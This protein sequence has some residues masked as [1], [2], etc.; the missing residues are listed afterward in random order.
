MQIQKV[1]FSRFFITR[2]F[3]FQLSFVLRP[4]FVSFPVY[5]DKLNTQLEAFIIL[6]WSK[7][8][9]VVIEQDFGALFSFSLT[10]NSS[11]AGI[12]SSNLTFPSIAFK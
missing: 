4:T 10:E 7:K 3:F 6:P 8:L 12:G 5:N 1:I 9:S 11:N 2:V